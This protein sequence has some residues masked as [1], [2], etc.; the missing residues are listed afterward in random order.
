[1][2]YIGIVDARVPILDNT[3]RTSACLLPVAYEKLLRLSLSALDLFTLSLCT[4]S[5]TV[6][7]RPFPAA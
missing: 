4:S 2:V 7:S 1:M 5:R 6:D 3:C